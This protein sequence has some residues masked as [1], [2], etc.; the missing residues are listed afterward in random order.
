MVAIVIC[1]LKIR[2]F[3]KD[4]SCD[5][6]FREL[7]KYA[8]GDLVYPIWLVWQAKDVS[9]IGRGRGGEICTTPKRCQPV[10]STVE[11][12]KNKKM[13]SSTTNLSTIMFVSFS[14][15]KEKGG[16]DK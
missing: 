11:R 3:G 13:E 7:Y 16:I 6:Y 15:N 2:G 14:K 5:K 8:L 9:R 4:C 1:L 10:P 12:S